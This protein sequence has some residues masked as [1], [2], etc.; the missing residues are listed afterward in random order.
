MHPFRRFRRFRP[1]RSFGLTG[2]AGLLG[3]ALSL[4][5][6]PAAAADPW[7]PEK[8]IHLVSPSPPGGGTDAV[9]RLLATKLGELARWQV[10]VDNKPGAGNNIGLE[11]GAKAPPDGYTAVLG[12]TSN[13]AVNQFLYKKLSFDPVKDLTPVALIGTGVSVLVVPAA[14]PYHS[15]DALMAAARTRE[16]SYASSGTGTVGHLVAENLR[17]ARGARVLHVPY[18][19]GG[20][21]IADTLGGQVDFYISSLVS[22]VPLIKERKLRAL[23]VTS[24]ARD[25]LLPEVPT[26]VES[27]Y[28]GFEYYTLYGVV[29][30]ARTPD[31]VVA[32][33][34]HEINRV[35][36][37][38]GVKESLAARGIYVKP[39]TPADFAA[40]L[41]RERSKWGAVVKASGATAD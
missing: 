10:V 18:K 1:S 30:P 15:L 5:A 14:S 26:F 11:F 12:E 39:G 40:F 9:S 8:V 20:P 24:G 19:G 35:L 6:A 22:A 17:V 23:A 37:A 16:L 3:L 31:N 21:A 28:A 13:L 38:P 34:N 32:T 2:L 33:M 36:D 29:V 41:T 27:G 25:P 4:A 7:V